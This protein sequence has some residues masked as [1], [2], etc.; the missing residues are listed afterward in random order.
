MHIKIGSIVNSI[1]FRSFCQHGELM[2]AM[3]FCVLLAQSAYADEPV[4]PPDKS[5]IG[6]RNNPIQNA[7]S[8]ISTSKSG[9]SK[10]CDV[11]CIFCHI[12]HGP[13]R[14]IEDLKWTQNNKVSPTRI[15]TTN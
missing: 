15:P 4:I 11:I 5:D 9:N 3:I 6:S 12:P 10:N 8:L 7:T 2:I 14:S 13:N 1:S